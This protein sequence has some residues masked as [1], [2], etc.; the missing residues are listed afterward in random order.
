MAW[1][2][3]GIVFS[4]SMIITGNRNSSA[5]R[6]VIGPMQAMV[7]FDPSRRASSAPPINS[8]KLDTVD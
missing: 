2:K 6:A 5:V 4:P 7:V 3:A 1:A 8:T